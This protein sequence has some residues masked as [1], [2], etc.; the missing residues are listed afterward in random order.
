MQSCKCSQVQKC[1]LSADRVPS[2]RYPARQPEPF[3]GRPVE[4]E[5]GP[6]VA[7]GGEYSSPTA[8]LHVGLKARPP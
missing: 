8:V 3:A 5:V 1:K 6:A 2:P 4:P 7:P